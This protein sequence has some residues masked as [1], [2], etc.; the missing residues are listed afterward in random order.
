VILQF[1]QERFVGPVN[2][3][4][5]QPHVTFCCSTPDVK[6]WQAVACTGRPASGLPRLDRWGR[7]LR[8]ERPAAPAPATKAAPLYPGRRRDADRHV[9]R[10]REKPVE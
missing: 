5:D 3:R 2:P 6:M 1:F 8:F 4:I 9:T 7:S 10:D